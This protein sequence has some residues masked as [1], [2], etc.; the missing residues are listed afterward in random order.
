MEVKT[1]PYVTGEHV[2]MDVENLL[3]CSPAISEK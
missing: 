2:Q 1:I 3:T